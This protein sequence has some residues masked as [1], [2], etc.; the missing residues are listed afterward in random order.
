MNYKIFVNLVNNL[1][2]K[3]K[4]WRHRRWQLVEREIVVLV[5]ELI[6]LNRSHVTINR[7]K[8]AHEFAI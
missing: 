4:Q 6:L 1:N 8:F 2:I 5:V 3:V 7:S